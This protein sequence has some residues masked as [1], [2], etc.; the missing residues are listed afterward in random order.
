MILSAG[1]SPAWQQTM[2]FER[3]ELG[4]VNRAK[5]VGWCTA[6]KVLNVGIAASRL[7]NR[8]A[9]LAPAGGDPLVKMDAE[10][11]SLGVDTHWIE[12]E[13]ATRICTTLVETSRSNNHGGNQ[14]VTLGGNDDNSDKS[15][16]N[17]SMPSITELVEEARP[18]SPRELDLYADKFK[19]LAADAAVVVISGSTPADVPTDFYA[20][21]LQETDHPAILDFRGE[22]LLECLASKPLIVKPN[23]QELAETFADADLGDIRNN[24]DALLA[25]MRRLVDLGAQWVVVTSGDKPVHIV[26]RDANYLAEPPNI[27]TIVNPIGSGD[28]MSAGIAR[29]IR[30]G[31][32]IVESIRLGIAA[33]VDN[34]SRQ[35]PARIKKDAVERVIQSVLIREIG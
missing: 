2:I 3:L 30:C 31:L 12:T 19:S 29:G 15:A 6:G 28:S 1:L 20:R 11:T 35:L 23:R 4:E 34:V 27:E 8:A 17:G 22:A 16:D 26:S 18:I 32:S 7:G 25:A 5:K 13:S 9:T 14:V 21:L 33:G 24:D 10:L